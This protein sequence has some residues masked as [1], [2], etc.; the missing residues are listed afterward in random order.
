MLVWHLPQ[1]SDGLPAEM[2]IALA[3]PN[4]P[5]VLG[6]ADT[7]PARWFDE[8]LALGVDD[9]LYLPQTPESLGMAAA[10]AR[11]HAQPPAVRR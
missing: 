11:G 1:D 4:G 8:A 7:H 6:L 10:E 3:D 5:A 9:I 2:R